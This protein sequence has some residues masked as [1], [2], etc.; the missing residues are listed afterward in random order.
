M[1]EYA[2]LFRPTCPLYEIIARIHLLQRRLELGTAAGLHLFPMVRGQREG[3]KKLRDYRPG[4]GA[5]DP[6]ALGTIVPP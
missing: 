1:A 5:L 2:S 6:F 4:G 3:A